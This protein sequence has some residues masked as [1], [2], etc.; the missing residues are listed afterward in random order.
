MTEGYLLYKTELEC[1]VNYM[2]QKKEYY[3]FPKELLALHEGL[4]ALVG[5]GDV[6]KERKKVTL[7][8]DKDWDG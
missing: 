5:G 8:L 6:E 4:E 1:Q 2:L 7:V 3:I